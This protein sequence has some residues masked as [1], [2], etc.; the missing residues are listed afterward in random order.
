MDK[1]DINFVATMRFFQYKEKWMITSV[2]VRIC[3][4]NSLCYTFKIQKNL[5]TLLRV[6]V[7][8]CVFS[9]FSHSLIYTAHLKVVVSV[10]A[11]NCECVS[12]FQTISKAIKV[13]FWHVN[14]AANWK[15]YA[16]ASVNWY[17]LRAC[18]CVALYMGYASKIIY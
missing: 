10:C 15:A 8:L 14:V 7:K 16:Y 5:V 6:Y 13:A 9:Y 11:C 17:T 4:F 12:S 3:Q 1:Y 18:A 2:M